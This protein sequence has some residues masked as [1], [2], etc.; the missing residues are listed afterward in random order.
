MLAASDEEPHS[1]NQ[2][3]LCKNKNTSVLV[4]RDT[5]LVTAAHILFC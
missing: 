5:K 4:A 3:R 1:N 2:K